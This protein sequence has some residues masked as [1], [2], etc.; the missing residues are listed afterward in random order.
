MVFF[1]FFILNLNERENKKPIKNIF[2]HSVR[3]GQLTKEYVRKLVVF[4]EM[5]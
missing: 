4:D 5:K 2:E 3:S 1:F